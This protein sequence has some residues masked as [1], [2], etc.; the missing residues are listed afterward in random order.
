[1][2]VESVVLVLLSVVVEMVSD[3]G[4]GSGNDGDRGRGSGSG[5]GTGTGDASGSG[6]GSGARQ[7]FSVFLYFL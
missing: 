2:L 1:M 5:T 3:I 6:S 4:R 7:Y